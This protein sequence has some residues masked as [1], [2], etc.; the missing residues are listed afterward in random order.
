M[1]SLGHGRR[2]KVRLVATTAALTLLSV[3]SLR[4]QE[5]GDPGKQK[6][7]EKKIE[8]LERR[9]QELEKKLEEKTGTAPVETATVGS[10]SETP[11]K[12]PLRKDENFVIRLGQTFWED[13]N[14]PA[15]NP[16]DPSA[17]PPRRRRESAPFDAPPFPVGE[18][19]MNG[20]VTIGDANVGTP[21]PSFIMDTLYTGPNG[22]WWRDKRL[23][24]YGW[25]DTGGNISTSTHSNLPTG[26]II[27]P[28][29][30]EIDQVTLYVERR[31]DEYQQDHFD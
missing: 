8:E 25:L 17:P 27:R 1:P 18:W 29:K 21:Y 12:T 24:I 11:A 2:R 23:A 31:P 26:Y 7:L 4:A 6:E 9:N 5:A 20:T 22:D 16:P 19:L 3:S 13:L 15:Y 10:G 30:V 14:S 28:N